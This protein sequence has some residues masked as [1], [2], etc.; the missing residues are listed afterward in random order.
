MAT[1]KFEKDEGVNPAI[2]NQHLKTTLTILNQK[3]KSQQDTENT[4]SRL[5]QENTELGDKISAIKKEL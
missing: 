4:I 1:L 5:R 3:L 2:E